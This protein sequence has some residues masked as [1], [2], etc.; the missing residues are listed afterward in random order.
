MLQG[1]LDASMALDPRKSKEADEKISLSSMPGREEALSKH[2]TFLDDKTTRKE[3]VPERAK[4]HVN[5]FIQS[6]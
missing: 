3:E 5:Q 2:K 6:M 1:R 4:P